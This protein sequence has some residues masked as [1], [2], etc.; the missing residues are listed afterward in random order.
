MQYR[1]L[2]PNGIAFSLKRE[3][4]MPGARFEKPENLDKEVISTLE[5]S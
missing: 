5:G 2:G 4:V 1:E 3:A